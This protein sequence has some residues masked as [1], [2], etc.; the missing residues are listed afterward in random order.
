VTAD[1]ALLY[2]FSTIAQALGGAIALLAAFALYRLQM[3]RIEMRA[4][5]ESFLKTQFAKDREPW[6]AL[7]KHAATENHVAFVAVLTENYTEDEIRTLG[8]VDEATVLRLKRDV[9]HQE[10]ITRWLYASLIASALTILG[11]VIVLA[12]VDALQSRACLHAVVMISGPALLAAC[13]FLYLRL[14]TISLE[15]P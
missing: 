13:L 10:R 5:E 6:T 8:L 11:S 14:I 2:T 3:L 4:D 12:L 7:R 9:R 1:S 15:M